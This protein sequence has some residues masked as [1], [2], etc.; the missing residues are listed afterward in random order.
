[1]EARDFRDD[2]HDTVPAGGVHALFLRRPDAFENV[3]LAGVV[4]G[5]GE[6]EALQRIRTALREH[7]GQVAQVLGADGNVHRRIQQGVDA[8]LVVVNLHQAYGALGGAGLVDELGF[9][10]D[11]CRQQAPVPAHFICVLLDDAVIRADGGQAA[12]HAAQVGLSDLADAAVSVH[13]GDPVVEQA[14]LASA[15]FPQD[16]DGAVA[17]GDSADKTVGVE[18]VGLVHHQQVHRPVSEGIQV[19]GAVGR[20]DELEF[21]PVV[22]GEFPQDDLVHAHGQAP[23]RFPLE[24]DDTA[25]RRRGILHRGFPDG[26]GPQQARREDE[27]GDQQ[28]FPESMLHRRGD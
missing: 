27:R 9:V 8:V 12:S 14:H 7:P 15:V 22:I 28:I 11:D 19:E 20:R 23:H 18:A 10:I 2:G 13:L 4:G 3:A 6:F 17:I 24:V 26:S 5:Q 21:Q 16:P 25:E 1:M